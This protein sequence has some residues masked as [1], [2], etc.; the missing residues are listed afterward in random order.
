MNAPG[1]PLSL[2]YIRHIRSNRLLFEAISSVTPL[3][4]VFHCL[5][6]QIQPIIDR[7]HYPNKYW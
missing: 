1:C 4:L 3:S 5:E 7:K 2:L 6:K